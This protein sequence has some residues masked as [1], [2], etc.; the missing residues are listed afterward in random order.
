MTA[1]RLCE[2]SEL[3]ESQPV[4][5]TVDGVRV[6]VVRVGTEIFAIEDRCSHQRSVALSDGEIDAF[7]CTIE[8]WK[9]GSRFSL[10]TGAVLSMPATEDVSTFPTVT[11]PDGVVSVVLPDQ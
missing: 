11:D 10:R 3:V 5:V 9:H 4:Q 1:H 6:A 2:M 7:D 8:C